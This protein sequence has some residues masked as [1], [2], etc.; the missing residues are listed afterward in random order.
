MRASVRDW[1]SRPALGSATAD[2]QSVTNLAALKGLAPVSALSGTSDGRAALAANY[3][4]TGGIQTGV[5]RQPTLCLSRNS[6]SRLCATPSSRTATL[7]NCGRLGTTLGAAYEARAHYLDRE[8]FTS[9]SKAVADVIAYANS[10]S[11][12]DSNAAKY[13][14]A[15]GTTNGKKPASDEAV[16]IFNDS[17]ARPIFLARAMGGLPGLPAP[18]NMEIPARFRRNPHLANHRAGLFQ[19]SGQQRRL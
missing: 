7:L 16:A 17:A 2:A 9:I 1:A 6:S 8:S 5:V 10:T 19:R 11:G 13:F 18:T 4:V 12:S 15:N 3:T 14:F